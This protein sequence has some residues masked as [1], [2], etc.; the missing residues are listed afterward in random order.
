MSRTLSLV[1]LG[2]TDL[3]R[4][5]DFYA[6]T[7]WKVASCSNEHIV[8]LHGGGTT[9]AL[10]PRDALLE[11]CGLTGNAPTPGGVTLACNV[12]S[13]D[14]VDA[15][16]AQVVEAGGRLI[17]PA[18]DKPWGYGGYFADPDGHP[19][20]VAHVPSLT[21]DVEGRIILDA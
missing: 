7:G 17:A 12:A 15:R 14:E 4:S 9:I 10:F 5:H 18:R 1:T 3:A 11:D 16:L 13:R 19:W 2:V 20:E 8:F 21:L 6:R